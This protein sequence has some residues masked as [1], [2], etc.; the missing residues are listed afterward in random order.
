[1]KSKIR[2]HTKIAAAVFFLNAF[3]TVHAQP[4]DRAWFGVGNTYAYNLVSTICDGIVMPFFQIFGPKGFNAEQICLDPEGYG[5]TCFKSKNPKCKFEGDGQPLGEITMNFKD[6][7][8]PFIYNISA[9]GEITL[10][11]EEFKLPACEDKHAKNQTCYK[12]DSLSSKQVFVMFSN[13]QE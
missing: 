6:I 13:S 4:K 9:V 10:S 8:P 7:S 12:F 1:M 3:S 2:F 11:G 5:Y